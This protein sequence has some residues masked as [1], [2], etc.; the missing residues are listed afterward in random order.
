MTLDGDLLPR[1]FN[2]LQDYPKN[3]AFVV[4]PSRNGM[5]ATIMIYFLHDDILKQVPTWTM[6]RPT[7][8]EVPV[9]NITITLPFELL[10]HSKQ[11][12]LKKLLDRKI[13]QFTKTLEGKK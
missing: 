11:P 7:G 6:L 10:L 13:K 1:E 2:F 4:A 3:F 9:G 5:K 12:Y 8:L